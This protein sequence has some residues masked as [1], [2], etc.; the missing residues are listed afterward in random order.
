MGSGR[1]DDRGGVVDGCRGERDR[2][3]GFVEV[4]QQQGREFERG[5]G[6]HRDRKVGIV[7][8]RVQDLRG[9]APPA[10][11]R[12]HFGQQERGTGIARVAGPFREPRRFE[13]VAR[14]T[15]FERGCGQLISRHFLSD[16]DAPG[17]GG[18]QWF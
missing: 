9:V 4:P 11:R 6:P 3:F 14:G 8:E 7:E 13:E 16:R 10:E 18:G 1:A 5:R 15:L 12:A 17:H 2:P